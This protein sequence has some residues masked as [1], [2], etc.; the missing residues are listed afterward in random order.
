VGRWFDGEFEP[1]PVVLHQYGDE[2]VA[3]LGWDERFQRFMPLGDHYIVPVHGGRISWQYEPT[4]GIR[5]GMPVKEF[6]EV[7]RSLSQQ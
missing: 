5:D 3:L 4:D 2:L 1:Y 6:V 7:L